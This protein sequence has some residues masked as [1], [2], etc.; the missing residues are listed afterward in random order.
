MKTQ[1]LALLLLLPA[2][3]STPD[4]AEI[5]TAE[6]IEPRSERALDRIE[7]RAAKSIEAFK[8]V[9]ETWLSGE[10]PGPLQMYRLSRAFDALETELKSGPGSRD[11]RLLAAT[12]SDPD[13][14]SEQVTALLERADIP[15]RMVLFLDRTG[16][17]NRAVEMIERGDASD[18]NG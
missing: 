15:D 5:C 7:K 6:W 17:L 2:C 11:L 8:S 14:I 9:S 10:S 3:A 16:L 13:F 4:P 18:P 12:C 1:F